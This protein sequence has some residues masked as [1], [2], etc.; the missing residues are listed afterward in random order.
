MTA[1]WTNSRKHF[2]IPTSDGFR[3]YDASS[4]ALKVKCEEIPHGVTQV[5]SYGQSSLFFIVG[6]KESVD[7]PSNKLTLWDN[8]AKNKVAEVAF[9]NP[10]FDL[11][12]EK[13][14]VVLTVNQQV[15]VFD[16]EAE[17]GLDNVICKFEA[18][19]DRIG[20]V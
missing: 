15:M 16:F 8:H 3:I 10:I 19:V 1:S 4:C 7:F 6:S 20:Q 14:W 11:K 18:Q 2:A 17:S 9:I 12:V 13:G 5:Q